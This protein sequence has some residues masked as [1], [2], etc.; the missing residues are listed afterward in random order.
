MV[1]KGQHDMG[2]IKCRICIHWDKFYVP[3]IF[4]PLKDGDGTYK[5]PLIPIASAFAIAVSLSFFYLP[6]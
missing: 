4:F 2:N 1:Q 5:I 6:P 3:Q